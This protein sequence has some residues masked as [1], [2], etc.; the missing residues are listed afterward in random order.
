M[1]NQSRASRV[2]DLHKDIGKLRNDVTIIFPHREDKDIALEAAYQSVMRCTES[3]SAALYLLGLE[4][5]R[6]DEKVKK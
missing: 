3:L 5:T 6:V 2:F 1:K 4:A